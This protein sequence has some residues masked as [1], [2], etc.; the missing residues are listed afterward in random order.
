MMSR[1]RKAALLTYLIRS[2]RD[3]GS[4]CGET[5]IQKAAY[6]LQTLT[7]LDMG[8]EFILYKH[9]P[10]SFDLRADLTALRADGFATLEA[11]RPY[12]SRFVPTERSEYVQGLY[13]KT[14]AKYRSAMDFVSRRLGGKDVSYLERAATAL[15][16]LEK[17]PQDAPP[18]DDD[19]AR[20]VT[21][22]KPHI[23]QSQALEAVRE[24]RRI[25]AEAGQE[26]P[27]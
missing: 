19:M 17:A 25:V 8:Y 11:H 7:Y 6:F 24:I 26:F 4:W 18:G 27:S 3:G 23:S 2:L 13:P 15:Y 14:L 9:G 1:M 22:L 16:V 5:H 21:E 10:F 12:G 20:G